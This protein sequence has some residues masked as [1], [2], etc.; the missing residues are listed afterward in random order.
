[1]PDYMKRVNIASQQL[2]ERLGSRELTSSSWF[3][4]L[5]CG[6]SEVLYVLA[7]SSPAT[8]GVEPAANSV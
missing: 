1:M 6:H 3:P 7:L 5:A 8:A 4:A 2:H